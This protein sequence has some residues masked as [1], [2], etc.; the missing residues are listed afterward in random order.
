MAALEYL[1][2]QINKLQQQSDQ[3]MRNAQNFALV[4]GLGIQDGLPSHISKN[5]SDKI[6][7]E[8]NREIARNKVNAIRQQINAAR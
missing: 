7:V 3:S 4:N 8:G 2:D 6:S 1:E 5:G